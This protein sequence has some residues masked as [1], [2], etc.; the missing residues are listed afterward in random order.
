M[1]ILMQQELP[2]DHYLLGGLGVADVVG[3]TGRKKV[4][5]LKCKI[6]QGNLWDLSSL[7]EDHASFFWGG[8]GGAGLPSCEKL[9]PKQE[10]FVSKR[11]RYVEKRILNCSSISLYILLVFLFV[12]QLRPMLI[13]CPV[14]CY[15]RR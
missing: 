4:G 9:E 3:S 10:R 15:I 6:V 13:L 12:L 5:I 1:K 14:F 7:K 8:E 2:Y 11:K